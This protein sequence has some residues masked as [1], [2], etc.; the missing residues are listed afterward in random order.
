[1]EPDAISL[2]VVDDEKRIRSFLKS[3]LTRR[4]FRVEEASSGEDALDRI[5][6]KEFHVVL[7]DLRLP[8]MTGLEALRVIRTGEPGP[9]VIII[10]GHGAIDTAIEA[11]RLG[12]YH[13]ITKPFKLRE[14]E[15]HI[16]KASEKVALE[17]KSRHL[18]RL[19]LT[20]APEWTIV[21]DSPGI[22]EV[23]RL[24]EKMAP[25]DSTVLI[26][27]ESGTGKELVARRI[28]RLSARHDA[29]FVAVNCATFQETLLETELFGHEKGA[30]TGAFQTRE[31]LFEVAQE[32]TLFLDEIVEMAP[33]LQVKLLR[34]LQDGEIRR[35]GSERTIRVDVRIL[36][37]TNVDPSEAVRDGRFRED[38]FYRLNVLPVSV[39]PLRDRRDDIRALVHHFLS[40]IPVPGKGPFTITDRALDALTRYTWPGNVRELKNTMER[41]KILSEGNVVDLADVP[42]EVLGVESPGEIGATDPEMPLADVERRHILNVLR[43]AD[44]NRAKAARTLGISTR[45]LY[46]RLGE[47]DRVGVLPPDLKR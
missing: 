31:G 3:E 2:L 38:L 36:A 23:L 37:A 1:M 11:I 40:T 12:A 20:D 4:G 22:R 13:Y 19:V 15:I 7:M 41:M 45:T 16:R 17:R 14:L 5:A 43:H 28:H 27:G 29:P 30:F 35:V 9:E 26:T 18:E 24:I 42:R 25:S 46:N 47:Y 6:A 10:T 32:G 21:G 39:P 34:A 44:N 33:T 8:G